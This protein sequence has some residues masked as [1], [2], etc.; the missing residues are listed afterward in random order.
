MTRDLD[1]I[2]TLIETKRDDWKRLEGWKGEEC[3]MKN[4][5]SGRVN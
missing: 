2:L 5:E 1:L 3:Q 4:M